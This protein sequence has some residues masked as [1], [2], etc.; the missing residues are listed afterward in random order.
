VK[1]ATIAGVVA[2]LQWNNTGG[3][4]ERENLIAG[5]RDIADRA[6]IR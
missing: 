4:E 2:L 5:L 1:P 6:G 3:D